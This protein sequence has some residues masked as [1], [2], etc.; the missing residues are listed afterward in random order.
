MPDT[1]QTHVVQGGVDCRQVAG[2]KAAARPGAQVLLCLGVDV[3]VV[4]A[5]LEILGH[6]PLDIRAQGDA[7]ILAFAGPVL[8]G[9]TGLGQG[10]VDRKGVFLRPAAESPA[11]LVC[12]VIVITPVQAGG[13]R[14]AGNIT[15]AQVSAI[16]LVLGQPQ[17]ARTVIIVDPLQV[18]AQVPAV[19][20]QEVE[21]RAGLPLVPVRHVD[22]SSVPDG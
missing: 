10:R 20:G 16:P 2:R 13:Q 5:D 3:V 22:I 4:E 15:G 17:L 7:G 6:L 19:G 11:A 14:L 18:Q 12:L 21:I 9:V 8:V 1:A